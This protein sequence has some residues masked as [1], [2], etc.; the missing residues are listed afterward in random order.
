MLKT[1]SSIDEEQLLALVNATPDNHRKLMYMLGFYQGMRISEILALKPVHIDYRNMRI[2]IK[3]ALTK[4]GMPKRQKQRVVPIAPE[5]LKGLKHLP[6]NVGRRTMQNYITEDAE[7]IL[8]IDIHPHTLRHSSATHYLTKKGWTID[9]VRQFLG[10][11]NIATTQIYL[12]SNPANLD[13]VMWQG[14][15]VA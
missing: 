12:H 13:K 9:Q 6:F 4:S 15:E 1:I 10:H 14:V 3:E 11:S 7:A 2:N 5:V 8:G